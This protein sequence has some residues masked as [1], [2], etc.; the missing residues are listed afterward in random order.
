[1]LIIAGKPIQRKCE[2]IIPGLE[3]MVEMMGIVV[4]KISKLLFLLLFSKSIL[5]T[6]ILAY[7][8]WRCTLIFQVCGSDLGSES[9]VTEFVVD[10]WQEVLLDSLISDLLLFLKGI[11]V[12]GFPW[13]DLKRSSKPVSFLTTKT[14]SF[15][16]IFPSTCIT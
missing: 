14:T 13:V 3:L 10:W 9:K 12:K 16:I 11:S 5:I 2:Q 8:P 1:M 15:I 4:R 6:S 7:C